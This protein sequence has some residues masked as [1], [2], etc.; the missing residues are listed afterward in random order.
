MK[1][2]KLIIETWIRAY[3]YKNK[4]DRGEI[5]YL[6]NNVNKDEIIFDIGAHKGGYLYFF[7]KKVG[8]KGQIYACEPQSILFNY[9]EQLK[10]TFNWKNV[11]IENIALS[12]TISNVKL[13]IPKNKKDKDSSPGATILESNIKTKQFKT[14]EVNTDTIDNYCKT[15]NLIPNFIKVDV[16]G[17]ELNVLKGAFNTLKNYKPKLIVGIE[18]R[19]IGRELVMETIDYMQKLNYKVYFINDTEKV[20]FDNFDFDIHQ[21]KSSNNYYCNNFIFE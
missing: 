2:I 16:E 3:R 10:S 14:E 9:L 5:N 8:K 6:L 7:K 15:N 13:Y 18:E 17:N 19:H 4:L 12:D 1:N 20:S 21:N 11:K